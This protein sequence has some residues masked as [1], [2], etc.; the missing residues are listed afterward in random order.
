MAQQLKSPALWWR[1]LLWLRFSPWPGN[2]C[3]LQGQPNKTKQNKNR[4]KP[5]DFVAEEADAQ[6]DRELAWGPTA[7]RTLNPC[8]QLALSLP[9][10]VLGLAL[11][12]PRYYKI[13]KDI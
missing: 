1:L 12:F 11:D 9:S 6:R 10:V 4:T 8:L 5:P 3:M 2:F 7:A 13:L